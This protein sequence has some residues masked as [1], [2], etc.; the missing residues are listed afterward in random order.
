[1]G[2]RLTVD[3]VPVDS[4]VATVDLTA[5]KPGGDPVRRQN[6]WA[7]F[8][9]TLSQVPE[10]DRVALKVE[11]SDLDLPGLE[12][13]PASLADLGFP[14]TTAA[15]PGQP[16]VRTNGELFTVD[17]ARIG[18]DRDAGPARRRATPASIAP[19][20]VWL[21]V[22]RDGK[23][24]A[25]VGGDRAELARWREGRQIRVP[26]FA[27][28]LTRPTY[29]THDFLWVG[30]Q[31][32]GASRAVGH[33]HSSEPGGYDAGSSDPGV[34]VVAAGKVS[35]GGPGRPRRPT[36]RR[37]VRGSAGQ[38]Y[39]HRRG[40]GGA[41]VE[42]N[43]GEPCG[44]GAGGAVADPRQG[45]GV[46]RPDPAGGP[47]THGRHVSGAGVVEPGRR[48]DHGG[49][50]V[51]RACGTVDHDRQRRA[52]AGASPPTAVR[53]CCGQAAAGSTSP[54]ART[55]PSPPPSGSTTTHTKASARGQP[56]G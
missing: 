8:V 42:R 32:E 25:A 37:R 6:L 44:A 12:K 21:A 30:G 55:S 46:G 19:G 2:T 48:A 5:T 22:S 34:C 31:T 54:R 28:H 29:D 49:R 16:V 3:A 10:V 15:P 9:A 35:G 26:S 33:Q 27:T 4:G 39:A 17:P 1:M 23:E 38:R 20:W 47:G 18:E 24:M 56:F 51:G 13:A 7:Q 36:G 53:S 50:G 45:P 14:Q 52:W 41:L 11:G 40:G 43:T